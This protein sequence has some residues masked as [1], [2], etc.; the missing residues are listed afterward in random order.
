LAGIS[1]DERLSANTSF[2]SGVQPT[3]A[4]EKR[5]RE[6]KKIYEP[7]DKHQ[8]IGNRYNECKGT[9]ARVPKYRFM[10][11]YGGSGDGAPHIF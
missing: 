6:E 11:T 5:L 8:Q 2:C 4:I 10:K 1:E 3:S 7:W 9:I